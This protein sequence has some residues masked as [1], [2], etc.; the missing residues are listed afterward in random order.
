MKCL[1]YLALFFLAFAAKAQPIP[2]DNPGFEQSLVGWTVMDKD[3]SQPMSMV[4]A[5]AA[6]EGQ[7]GLRIDDQ[8][9]KL[10]GSV[11]SQS[12]PVV[13]GQSYR[14]SFFA[15][16]KTGGR[17][18]VFLRFAN[19][20]RVVIDPEHLASAPI[21]KGG[22]QWEQYSLEARAP[23][24]A[25]T[26]SIWVRSWSGAVGVMDFDDFSLEQMEGTAVSAPQTLTPA[27]PV[28]AKVTALK[29]AKVTAVRTKPAT[30]IIKVDDLKTN[31]SGV[32][33]AAWNRFADM[34]KQRHL[35]A[36]I[37]IICNSLEGEK[38]KYFQWIK[39]QQASGLFEF[40][41]HG[42]DH[43]EWKEG[44]KTLHEFQGPSYETQKQH[45]AQ[46]QA[47]AKAKLGFALAVFGPGYGATDDNTVK[48]LEEDPDTKIWLYSKPLG[49]DDKLPKDKVILDRIWQV[50]I[51]HPT[52]VPNFEMVKAGYEHN[53]TRDYFVIQGHPSHWKEEGWAEFEKML[54]YFTA[55]G[56]V[57]MTPS[58]YVASHPHPETV[59]SVSPGA[60]P[61]AA[62]AG[63]AGE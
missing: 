28:A 20:Q 11:A 63:A 30:I 27:Q 43:L 17:G 1:R 62:P 47:L 39:D 8:D 60:V 2:L 3:K 22:E 48:V 42:Y 13:A 29:P 5:D 14:V 41:N 4:S 34:I 18:A 54:D 44:D 56:A 52:F 55:Q 12:V 32:M 49:A 36:G 58:E 35:K 61:A 57:F 46:S 45:V 53:P 15:R 24:G 16:T 21:S 6:H 33:P 26:L 37:G 59:L 25:A 50:N 40:W 31:A 7:L 9:A 51:E 10:G 23:D 38:P 19:A